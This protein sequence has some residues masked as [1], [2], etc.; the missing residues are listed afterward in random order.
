MLF[1]GMCRALFHVW[2]QLLVCECD[3]LLAHCV[4]CDFVWVVNECNAAAANVEIVGE[5]YVAYTDEALVLEL[6]YV[7]AVELLHEVMEDELDDGFAVTK[8]EHFVEGDE[9]SRLA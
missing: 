5:G 7:V 2:L 3:A 4:A 8:V 6:L 9:M 1:L